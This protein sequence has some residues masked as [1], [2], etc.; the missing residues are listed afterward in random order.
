MVLT[1]LFH[2][3]Q[4]IQGDWHEFES[5]A[6]R[7]ENER[8]DKEARHKQRQEE[9]ERDK[10]KRKAASIAG[11]VVDKDR[12]S[13]RIRPNSSHEQNLAEVKQEQ[14]IEAR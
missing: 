12:D 9:Y 4:D 8:K 3:L 7:K 13:K 1:Y 11:A 6:L 5:K 14:A 10:A 2:R